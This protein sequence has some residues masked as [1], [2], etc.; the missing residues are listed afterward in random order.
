MENN[1]LIYNKNIVEF[2]TVA[3]EFTGLLER[4]KE[5]TRDELIDSSLKI[6]PL[7][8]LKSEMLPHIEDSEYPES[9]IFVDENQYTL[10][11]NSV[12][13]SLEDKDDYVEIQ[14]MSINRSIDYLNVS[15]SELY[16]DIYQDLG[17]I[18]GSFRLL[19]E[20]IILGALNTC[21]QNFENYWGIRVII[22]MENLHKI[23]YSIKE[24]DF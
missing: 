2:I 5:L 6:L 9:E 15:L 23:K 13:H 24:D 8:Y 10:I 4:C 7:L 17:D 22:L 3:K 1:S 12:A 20:N 14:D 19:D 11:Q 16:A 21:K 18:I